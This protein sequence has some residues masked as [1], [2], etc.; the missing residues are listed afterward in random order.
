MS[1]A[2]DADILLYARPLLPAEALQNIEG[3]LA[4]PHCRP[5]G[6][7]QG[8]LPAYRDIALPLSWQPCCCRTVS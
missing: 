2:V 6:E 3:L 5:I 8:F 7:Q 1:S 4:L